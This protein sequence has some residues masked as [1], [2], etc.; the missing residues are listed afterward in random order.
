MD[1]REVGNI[2]KGP[3][4]EGMLALA[5]SSP[6]A[7]TKHCVRSVMTGHMDNGLSARNIGAEHRSGPS[8]IGRGER[9]AIFVKQKYQP[10]N[11]HL[12]LEDGV[13]PNCL[14]S[15]ILPHRQATFHVSFT[16]SGR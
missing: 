12:S 1:R 11:R 6:L 10:S 16:I 9:L 13:D 7:G 5:H 3:Q 8:S 15:I 4:A 2:W 14:N